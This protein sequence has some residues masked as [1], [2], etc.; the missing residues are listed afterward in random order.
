MLVLY[1][2]QRVVA[3]K[4]GDGRGEALKAI[5]SPR[6]EPLYVIATFSCPSSTSATNTFLPL[7]PPG[8]VVLCHAD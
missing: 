5:T 4:E 6:L 3:G 1:L 2:A 7:L 8:D